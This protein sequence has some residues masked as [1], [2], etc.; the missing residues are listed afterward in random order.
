MPLHLS[1]HHSRGAHIPGIFQ[2]NLGTGMGETI[3]L[4]LLA[5]E[6]SRADEHQ[7]QI[8]YLPVL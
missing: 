3:E 7:D 1:D 6:V 8:K 2:L 4:L 5:A